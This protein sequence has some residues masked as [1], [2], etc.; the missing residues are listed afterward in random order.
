MSPWIL[1]F[2]GGVVGIVIG[3]ILATELNGLLWKKLVQVQRETAASQ[4]RSIKTMKDAVALS[5]ELREERTGIGKEW[6]NA[7]AANQNAVKNLKESNEVR[8]AAD[9]DRERISA[10]LMEAIALREKANRETQ[11]AWE[12]QQS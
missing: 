7:V 12:K 6:E 8:D 10:E 3:W 4:A 2:G 5:Q 1:V 11:E 9:K